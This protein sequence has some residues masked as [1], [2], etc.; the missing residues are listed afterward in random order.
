MPIIQGDFFYRL[1]KIKQAVRNLPVQ[2]GAEAE[3]F[4]KDNFRLQGWQGDNGLEPWTKRK[5]DLDPGRA[6]LVG[7]AGGHLRRGL[8]KFVSGNNIQ[9]K[10]TGVATKYADVHNFG[11][12]IKMTPTQKQRK[13]AWAMFYRTGR[14]MYKAMALGKTLTIKIPA[15]KFIGNSKQLDRKLADL[16]ERKLAAALSS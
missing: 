9:V 7:K 5:N 6:I 2:I 12:T 11:A 14:P 15:R 16:V 13:W 8:R 1:E 10:V 3:G 4:F